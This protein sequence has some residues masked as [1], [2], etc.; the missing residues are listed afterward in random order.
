MADFEKYTDQP[1]YPAAA[2]ITWFTLDQALCNL[3]VFGDDSFL[4]IRA[5]NLAHIDQWLTQ[6]EY[7]L[8]HKLRED[9]RTPDL[10]AA[11]VAAQSQK[12]GATDVFPASPLPWAHGLGAVSGPRPTHR[13]P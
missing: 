11:C 9:E 7:D 12:K 2:E 10:E 13:R 5:S 4:R 1:P 6:L 8:P 3:R